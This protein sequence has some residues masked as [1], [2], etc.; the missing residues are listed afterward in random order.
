M[1]L[2]SPSLKRVLAARYGKRARGRFRKGHTSSLP[3]LRRFY[4][5][6]LSREYQQDLLSDHPSLRRRSE[7]PRSPTILAALQIHSSSNSASDLVRPPPSISQDV[8]SAVG[9]NTNWYGRPVSPFILESQATVLTS[10]VVSFFLPPLPPWEPVKL[11]LIFLY[12]IY[13]IF[14]SFFFFLF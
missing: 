1:N 2:P 11:S 9:T 13:N 5:L 6:F 10:V 7:Q 12:N 8:S 4:P 14:L 3:S